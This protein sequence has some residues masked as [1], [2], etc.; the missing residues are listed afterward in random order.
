MNF[1]TMFALQSDKYVVIE[2]KQL[3]LEFATTSTRLLCHSDAPI[4]SPIL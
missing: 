2:V 1:D 4:P 3:T